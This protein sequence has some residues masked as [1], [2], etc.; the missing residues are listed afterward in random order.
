[1]RKKLAPPAQTLYTARKP[2]TLS[3]VNEV[4]NITGI[5]DPTLANRSLK[6]TQINS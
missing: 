2:T 4:F 1:M 3:Q 5:D 6:G